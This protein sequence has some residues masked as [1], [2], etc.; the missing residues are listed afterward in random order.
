[1]YFNYTLLA[2]T[3]NL[4]YNIHTTSSQ[5]TVT[6]HNRLGHDLHKD[7]GCLINL[8]R[9]GEDDDANDDNASQLKQKLGDHDDD[10][11]D[12]IMGDDVKL[13]AIS[14]L[15]TDVVVDDDNVRCL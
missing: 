7:V 9:N 12:T 2:D 3:L 15:V 6:V 11:D 13:K 1:M 8:I 14:Q 5:D 10:N 4:L